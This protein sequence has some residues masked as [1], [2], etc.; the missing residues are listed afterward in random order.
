MLKEIKRGIK[1][2]LVFDFLRFHHNPRPLIYYIFGKIGK[3]I[4]ENERLLF[5]LTKKFKDFNQEKK[6]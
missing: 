2:H 3:A 1:Q 4:E 5:Q 6:E